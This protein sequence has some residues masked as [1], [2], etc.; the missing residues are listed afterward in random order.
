MNAIII[1]AGQAG[2]HIAH[3]LVQE[4]HQVTLIDSDPQ[5]IQQAE[6]ELDVRTLCAHGVSPPVLES[7]G[8][9][10]ADLVAAVTQSDEVNLIVALTAKQLGAAK[11]AARVFNPTYFEGARIAYRNLLGIDLLGLGSWTCANTFL[12]FFHYARKCGR[13]RSECDCS[14][15]MWLC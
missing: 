14:A 11:T 13:I 10:K 2:T 7:V 8:V 1:G 3:T 4:N 5:R 15:G 12:C 6:M 9:K